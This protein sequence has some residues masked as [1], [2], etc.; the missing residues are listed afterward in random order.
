MKKFKILYVMW[1]LAILMLILSS[2][3]EQLENH[4]F[5]GIAESNEVNINFEKSVEI[6][7]IYVVP[8]QHVTKGTLLLELDQPELA[9][10]LNEIKH[11]LSEYK[12]QQ[13]IENNKIQT[14][15]KEL[16][17]QKITKMNT[18]HSEIK[19]LESQHSLNKRLT[20][21]LKSIMD[22]DLS[23][24]ENPTT[25]FSSPLQLKIESLK[26][27]LR[28]TIQQID[29][30]IKA[31]KTILYSKNNPLKAKIQ[32]LEKEIE[33]LTSAKEKLL[34]HSENNGII[35]SINFKRGEIVSPFVPILNIYTQSPS[36]VK[37]FIHENVYNSISVND[38]VIVSSLTGQKLFSEGAVVG[39]GS[40]IIEFPER[41]RKRSEIKIWGR[42]VQ[43]RISEQNR[44]LLGEKV[45]IQSK[46]IKPF[47]IVAWESLKNYVSTIYKHIVSEPEHKNRELCK[48][49][50]K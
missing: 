48:L 23:S 31:L 28:L 50:E 39:V 8:G 17:A 49:I 47:N 7:N 16:N 38:K 14:Q 12:L 33:L 5:F 24:K 40:R 46:N 45:V 32:S 3:H 43:I 2:K 4:Q 42:E 22:V 15:L 36:Y 35:G 21:E 44:F 9:L 11:Q 41:L 19:Q 34:I 29:I 1:I 10:S 13:K 20:A 30:K 25:S 27:E 18:I 6:K 37:G 26:E